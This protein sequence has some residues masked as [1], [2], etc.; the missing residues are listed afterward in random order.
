MLSARIIARMVLFFVLTTAIECSLFAWDQHKVHPHV[1]KY[2]TDVSKNLPARVQEWSPKERLTAL[3][4]QIRFGSIK[5]DDP[6]FLGVTLGN[7]V[8]L[9]NTRHFHNP[10]RPIQDAGV[11]LGLGFNGTSSILWALDKSGDNA[12][13]YE[14]A[15]EYLYRSLTETRASNRESM[16]QLTFRSIGQVMHLI[17][18]LAQPEHSR[19]DNHFFTG[20]S[21]N[22]PGTRS[23]YE[24]DYW[25]A[26]H[27]D[28]FP[29]SASGAVPKAWQLF[30]RRSLSSFFDA[31]IY[32]GF[33]PLP[34]GITAG[35][36]EIINSNF[37]SLQTGPYE[38]TL[39]SQ[40]GGTTIGRKEKPD[41]GYKSKFPHPASTDTTEASLLLGRLSFVAVDAE[42]GSKDNRIYLAKTAGLSTNPFAAVSYLALADLAKNIELKNR[43]L[44]IWE[45][46]DQ[47]NGAYVG[48]VIPLAVSYAAGV[49]DFSLRGSLDF[50]VL[51]CG[52][53]GY[54]VFA[55]ASEEDLHG[56]FQ[57]FYDDEHDDRSEIPVKE[58]PLF[59]SYSLAPG[60]NS[61]IFTFKVPAIYASNKKSGKYMLVFKGKL[62]EE[63]DYV[64]GRYAVGQECEF[65]IAAS[66]GQQQICPG[67]SG[68][69]AN[70]VKLK[71]PLPQKFAQL[72]TKKLLQ[73]KSVQYTLSGPSLGLQ[74]Q[75]PVAPN[76]SFS[77]IPLTATGDYLASNFRLIT[78]TRRNIAQGSSSANIQV[79][80]NS[81]CKPSG[82]VTLKPV[83]GAN[84]SLNFTTTLCTDA[85]PDVIL[86]LRRGLPSL[87]ALSTGAF[88]SW[89]PLG[90]GGGNRLAEYRSI[91]WSSYQ[92][93][94][95]TSL[96]LLVFSGSV[97]FQGTDIEVRIYI[98]A[99]AGNNLGNLRVLY[100]STGD[101][102]P[103]V[104]FAKVTNEQGQAFAEIPTSAGFEP[105]KE[106]V[107]RARAPTTGLKPFA[108]DITGDLVS[109]TTPAQTGVFGPMR[110]TG[111]LEI[112][113]PQ[114]TL[115]LSFSDD[116]LDA[117]APFGLTSTV[118]N[119]PKSG[120]T[121][122]NT[123]IAVQADASASIVGKSTATLGDIAPGEARSADFKF[124]S[125]RTGAVQGVTA[126][127]SGN[128]NVQVSVAGKRAYPP[129]YPIQGSPGLTAL[130]AQAP[131][132]AARSMEML[133]MIYGDAVGQNDGSEKSAVVKHAQALHTA[134]FRLLAGESLQTII[135]DLILDLGIGDSTYSSYDFARRNYPAGKAWRDS[136]SQAL[137]SAFS[138]TSAAAL[139]KKLAQLSN[140]RPQFSI[141]FQNLSGGELQ[142]QATDSLGRV[143][144][145][146]RNEIPFAERFTVRGAPVVLLPSASFSDYSFSLQSSVNGGV[147]ISVVTPEGGQLVQRVYRGFSISNPAALQLNL[148]DLLFLSPSEQAAIAPPPLDIVS[149][150]VFNGQTPIDYRYVSVQFNQPQ[151]QATLANKA[152][153][154]FQ[155]ANILLGV[156]PQPDGRSV[157]LLI[158]T[159]VTDGMKI[160]FQSG[161]AMLA[162]PIRGG[163]GAATVTGKVFSPGGTQSASAK[164]T[165]TSR[166]NSIFETTTDAAGN[167]TFGSVPLGDARLDAVNGKSKGSRSA[168]LQAVG[169]TTAVNISLIGVGRIQGKVLRPDGAAAPSVNLTLS[170][171]GLARFAVTD[172]T[173]AFTFEDVPM[174]P[175][176]LSATDSASGQYASLQGQIYAADST[177]TL[178]IRLSGWP[179]AKLRGKVFGPNGLM[180][181]PSANVRI[182]N[183]K[184]PA[185]NQPLMNSTVTTNDR[186]EYSFDKIP[187]G[188]YIVTAFA[189]DGRRGLPVSITAG[190]GTET[191]KDLT[192]LGLGA[193]EVTVADA[194]GKARG[195]VAVAISSADLYREARSGSDGTARFADL[196]VG[197][198]RV[199]ASDPTNYGFAEG[200]AQLT[201]DTTATVTLTIVDKAVNLP[202]T[203]QDFNTRTY[204]V[205]RSGASRL[206]GDATTFS[207]LKINGVALN[208]TPI[209]SS[210]QDGKEIEVDGSIGSDLFVRRTIYA[211]PSAGYFVRHLELIEN[212]GSAPTTVRLELRDS[213]GTP[214]QLV[215]TST[216]TAFQPRDSYALF[217]KSN[218]AT[219][220]G[221]VFQSGEVSAGGALSGNEFVYTYPELVL[222][223]GERAAF[224]HFAFATSVRSSATEMARSLRSPPLES[225]QGLTETALN[226]LRNFSLTATS[227]PDLK[228]GDANFT[229]LTMD[230]FI[231]P[232][233]GVTISSRHKFFDRSVQAIASNAGTLSLKRFPAA[234]TSVKVV[235]PETQ[236]SYQQ[237]VVLVADQATSFEIKLRNT[238]TVSGTVIAGD[239][240]PATNVDVTVNNQARV[241]TSLNGKYQQRAVPVGIVEVRATDPDSKLVVLASGTLKDDGKDVG[242]ELTIDLRLPSYGTVRG[243]AWRGDGKTPLSNARI[244][245]I[246]GSANSQRVDQTITSINGF[247]SF[248]FVSLG[249]MQLTATDPVSGLQQTTTA[250]LTT[251][252]QILDVQIVFQETGTIAGTVFIGEARIIAPAAIISLVSDK[253]PAQ[254][255]NA[256][257]DSAG[258]FAVD[259]IPFG[260][261]A[262]TARP[263]AG[264][265]LARAAA[266]LSAT[267]LRANVELWIDNTPPQVRFVSPTPI[268]AITITETPKFDMELADT[269]SGLNLSTFSAK[270]DGTDVTGNFGFSAGHALWQVTAAQKLSHAPHQ[271]SISISDQSDNRTQAALGFEIDSKPPSLKIASP[272]AGALISGDQVLFRIEYADNDAGVDVTSAKFTLNT[273]D[274]TSSFAIDAAAAVWQASTLKELQRGTN[275]LTAHVADKLGNSADAQ[276]QFE[277]P[278]TVNL[279]DS[280]YDAN[281]ISYYLQQDGRAIASFD[282]WGGFPNDGSFRLKWTQNGSAAAFPS[283][284][285]AFSELAGRGVAM[286]FRSGDLW[287]TRH[288]YIPASGYFIRYLDVF[289]NAGAAAVTVSPTLE[290]ALAK[291]LFGPAAVTASS[292]GDTIFDPITQRD[293]W[294]VWDDNNETDPFD[295][296]GNAA[297]S[298]FVWMGKDSVASSATDTSTDALQ[299]IALTFKPLTLAP[300]DSRSYLTFGVLQLNRAAA[301]AAADRLVRLAPEVIVGLAAAQLAGIVNFDSASATPLPP[302]PELKGIVTGKFVAGDSVTPITQGKVRLQSR[303]VLF[304]RRREQAI[305][306]DGVFRFEKVP[307]ADFELKGSSALIGTLDVT[308]VQSFGNASETNVTFSAAGTSVLDATFRWR[309]GETVSGQLTSSAL[310]STLAVAS[311]GKSLLSGLPAGTFTFS[312]EIVP[313]AETPGSSYFYA[314]SLSLPASAKLASSVSIPAGGIYG[315]VKTTPGTV[316]AQA[317]VKL[318]KD[319]FERT[320][321][322][323]AFGNYRLTRVPPGAYS[324]EVYSA[325]RSTPRVVQPVTISDAPDQLRD[326]TYSVSGTVRVKVQNADGSPAGG[327]NIFL[328]EAGSSSF[329][330]AGATAADGTLTLL[331]V[332]EGPFTV[333]AADPNHRQRYTHYI[334]ATGAITATAEDVA[335]ALTLPRYGN[336]SVVVKTF[337]GQIAPG[338]RVEI[339]EFG[340]ADSVF[341]GNTD[342]SGALA[343]SDARE[344]TTTLT[345][346][347]P[348]H[349]PSTQAAAVTT[350]GNATTP[351][352][353][354]L[355]KY[356][357]LIVAVTRSGI[358]VGGAEVRLKQSYQTVES[359]VGI[360]DATGQVRVDSVREGVYQVLVKDPARGTFTSASGEITQDGV[361][362]TKNV[363]L[364]PLASLRVKVTTS[365]GAPGPPMSVFLIPAGTTF[366]QFKGIT[367]ST[368]QF[369][370]GTVAVGTYTV[371]VTSRQNGFNTFDRTVAVADGQQVE[372]A[373]VLAR[374][375]SISGKALTASGAPITSG[376]AVARSS[377]GL[378]L[379]S[380]N[381]DLAGNYLLTEVAAGA[382][383]FQVTVF[384]QSLPNLGAKRT[385]IFNAQGQALSFDATL[386]L[387]R[388]FGTVK[389]ESAQ[390]FSFPQVAIET[391]SGRLLRL[392]TVNANG[393]FTLYSPSGKHA[394][395][396]HPVN[397]AGAAELLATSREITVVADLGDV[398][399][400]DW[401]VRTG[402]LKGK[403]FDAN[404]AFV[405]NGDL[406]VASPA[407]F[408]IH[409]IDG[410]FS[411]RISTQA[412]GSFEAKIPEGPFLVR[413]TNRNGAW[414]TFSG[415]MV[416]GQAL[417]KDITLPAGGTVQGRGLPSSSVVLR[418]ASQKEHSS[419]QFPWFLLRTTTADAAGDFRF[420][421]VPAGNVE[422]LVAATDLLSAQASV[423][424]G[425]AAVASPQASGLQRLPANAYVNGNDIFSFNG[426]ASLFFATAAASYNP[427]R[428]AS[429]EIQASRNYYNEFPF[430][431]VNGEPFPLHVYAAPGEKGWFFS[432]GLLDSGLKVSRH[433]LA[434]ADGGLVRYLETITNPTDHAITAE[435]LISG[436][437]P[438][439]YPTVENTS[440]G[441]AILDSTD[442]YV[443]LRDDSALFQR[444]GLIF[445]GQSG[446][447]PRVFLD[448]GDQ[449]DS[450][451]AYRW[452]LNL[453]SGQ[454]MR[455]LHFLVPSHMDAAAITPM[456]NSVLSLMHPLA[457]Q[458]ITPEERATIVNF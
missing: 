74:D 105:S 238:G 265:G 147:E 218:Q 99:P 132:L 213:F 436:K 176:W 122:F 169:A 114:L 229:F 258:K 94:E 237:D 103:I 428:L 302:V 164:V 93:K 421:N 18:D 275:T 396:T 236:A 246:S 380:V 91:N 135:P 160:L 21:S 353:V 280:W 334:S 440:S 305:A 345:V 340:Q 67:A 411:Y 401:I 46:D 64:M 414:T 24:M 289:E 212:R 306:A 362:V 285:T 301:A 82:S 451:F 418:H 198:F 408:R 183:S 293:T 323:D 445:A 413:A 242:P 338:A 254:T 138:E 363:A 151:S 454:T 395:L 261:I 127:T 273:L 283:N 290:L 425:A 126:R 72:D 145:S 399:I 282:T 446:T 299:R 308:A 281:D 19:N 146:T 248:L 168:T 154:S 311:D 68:Q 422:V 112:S 319:S 89:W 44:G 449:G 173:G 424:A 144:D 92:T 60:V 98:Y 457:L 42:D 172:A 97:F 32:R 45:F 456:L 389:D 377:A 405:P 107:F 16:E 6:L 141:A 434:A 370:I 267:Q 209:G 140:A 56:R 233:A 83:P 433:V 343:I 318:K 38:L 251:H 119:A 397:L 247:F 335:I 111:T 58:E 3:K 180:P 86:F 310:K 84:V 221:H 108:L 364:P 181:F 157:V 400:G 332:R 71:K 382:D 307:L 315:A 116:L 452:T 444:L 435:I 321:T 143:L 191:Q 129:I 155:P 416:A 372:V 10:L 371:R 189:L 39:A 142:L 417:L 356:S 217:Q 366:P 404:G 329:T 77:T 167:F 102:V 210:V 17:E 300:G 170:G 136:A 109:T 4:A 117:G 199:Q 79:A 76:N 269:I 386:P 215:E 344:G 333:K 5:E 244:Q 75:G 339:V 268:P 36:S 69:L 403:L 51:E 426:T 11:T 387:A 336:L 96:C 232:Q 193:L 186:G 220:F 245:L 23:N 30:Q 288:I 174:Q 304:P 326:F 182:D 8:G 134:G 61:Q 25:L 28:K 384:E 342:A 376:R 195:N 388:V 312:F 228:F 219:I 231:I 346:T 130:R 152:I 328:A 214:V 394:L 367:D 274:V 85:C 314:S 347:D 66:P 187:A 351:V 47:V 27:F 203:L 407:M 81:T 369:N 196:P 252:K 234:A 113:Q 381:A 202:A 243:T 123:G 90:P 316:S 120:A 101:L 263:A 235:H 270:L 106:I 257:A 324:A 284:P 156:T 65:E 14:K 294:A 95:G 337:G 327:S 227:N 239:G 429:L 163:L 385:L 171:E 264:I 341:V 208:E 412:D 447:V 188:S 458:G 349:S 184:S 13:S 354:T 357:T 398:S 298:A 7:A 443:V 34:S 331:D 378:A 358:P 271:L 148:S 355:P 226:S 100:S 419:G 22:I 278:N 206:A 431:T 192:I 178:E 375:G 453:A 54:L 441:D 402:T 295:T 240:Q 149:A 423:S 352:T 200:S 201:P 410:K 255:F 216:G 162:K 41:D 230:N 415:E 175:F 393:T 225:R 259:S 374:Y 325:G 348:F 124:I 317:Q 430:L 33:S 211:D 88:A 158:S 179:T 70:S 320:A 286:Q 190:A 427:T 442:R 383:T 197:T 153:Y 450:R 297:A 104:G 256:V 53:D 287:V 194:A 322:A 330:T 177:Q 63:E 455:L 131:D 279:P 73:N 361:V 110:V 118:F 165:L 52:E 262:I 390:P 125:A 249:A 121:A 266:A 9:R 205:Q 50:D 432:G 222:N 365:D 406:H 35:L 313:P 448:L 115:G 166:D 49:L 373:F 55:N 253:A 48:Q 392:P 379:G 137:Q 368:G 291:R 277:F 204:E 420:D 29:A 296:V 87:G 161:S 80:D 20:G 159:P 224:L 37:N 15:K 250:T 359:V 1:T 185:P 40:V 31:D 272:Q 12:W 241:K 128:L 409:Q 78:A 2:A 292:S 223:P 59:A 260:N 276:A 360:T 133:G 26:N 139:Q 207:L 439:N 437:L 309:S 43:Y 438:A 350:I 62:G 57:L 150:S 303:H 391:D